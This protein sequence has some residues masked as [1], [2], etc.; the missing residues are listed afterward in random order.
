MKKELDDIVSIEQMPGEVQEEFVRAKL[1]I[2]PHY[3]EEYSAETKGKTI[4]IEVIKSK[5][6]RIHKFYSHLESEKKN[7][8]KS[9]KS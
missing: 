7:G 2:A 1:N 8:N 6:E 3:W 9:R 5:L 4:A